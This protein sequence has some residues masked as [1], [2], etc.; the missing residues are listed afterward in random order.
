VSVRVAL[1]ERSARGGLLHALRLVG[2]TGDETWMPSGVLNDAQQGTEQYDQ[3]AAWIRERIE[4]PRTRDSLELLVLDPT[5]GVCTWMNGSGTDPAKLA[6]LARMG[7]GGTEDIDGTGATAAGPVEFYASSAME[8]SVQPLGFEQDDAIATQAGSSTKSRV[9]LF[10]SRSKKRTKKGTK[11]DKS[12]PGEEQRRL[13]VLAL[14]DVPA[15]V[16]VD[17]LDRTGVRVAGV[18]S[19]WHALAMAW[20][21]GAGAGSR[22]LSNDP[23]TQTPSANDPCAVVVV[24]SSGRLSWC[25]CVLD[26]LICAGSMRCPMVRGGTDSEAQSMVALGKDDIARLASEWISWSVQNQTSPER[27]VC[28]LPKNLATESSDTTT[29]VVG[30]SAGQFGEAL[31]SSWRGAMLDM[32][33]HEDPLGA[34]LRRLV[35]FLESTPASSR[36][37]SRT[38][39]VDLSVRPGRQ[40]RTMFLWTGAALALCAVASGVLG[41][42][43]RSD[44]T[45]AGETV[46]GWNTGWQGHVK[47]VFPSALAPKP[48]F[49]ALMELEDELTRRR[50]AS[51]GPEKVSKARPV[52]TELEAVSLVVGAPGIKLESVMFDSTD[53]PQRVVVI[54]PTTSEAEAVLEAFKRVGGSILV[55]WTA[56][57]QPMPNSEERRVT[58][59]ARWPA[60]KERGTGK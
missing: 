47:E 48:G 5:G 38:S 8:S 39:L 1:L 3:G 9:K 60:T 45:R 18:A 36:P 7:N 4:G 35:S 15:R 42:R 23:L 6:S 11:G 26:R 51:S 30:L 37:D 29:S 19:F 25:W 24:E 57:I 43:F 10:A 41:L 31:V 49:T 22:R 54:A 56:D 44:A 34:T 32:V 40:H 27:I 52:L 12:N 28:V 53:R 20:S 55:E 50:I 58:Y 21:P 14:A 2:A 33:V 46:Q 59:I 17:A 16:L 13:A